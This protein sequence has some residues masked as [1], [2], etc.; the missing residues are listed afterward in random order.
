MRI[1]ARRVAALLMAMTLIGVSGNPAFTP[2][3]YAAEGDI[4][5]SSEET[6]SE[7]LEQP[8]AEPV[9]EAPAQTEPPVTEPPATEAPVQ[10]EPPAQTEPPVTEPPAT[11]ASVQTEPPATEP[12]VTEAPATE[13]PATEAPATEAPAQSESAAPAIEAS[14]QGTSEASTEAGQTEAKATEKE[15]EEEG[16]SRTFETQ[17]LK[18]KITLKLPKGQGVAESSTLV[19]EGV[20][21]KDDSKTRSKVDKVIL[22]KQR[23]ITGGRVYSISLKNKDEVIEIPEGTQ[24]TFEQSGGI[25]LNIQPRLQ[26]KTHIYN[27]SKD[28]AQEISASISLNQKQE[29]TGFSFST[30]KKLSAF[31]LIAEE[32]RANDGAAVSRGS[33]ISSIGDAGNFA[34]VA[35]A[36]NGIVENDSISN[37]GDILDSLAG[38]SVTLANAQ[39]GSDAAVVN[40]FTDSDGH[41]LTDSN[42]DQDPMRSVL[43]ENNQ[44]DVSGRMV[45]VNYVVTNPGA[46]HVSLPHYDVVSN[47]QAIDKDENQELGGRLVVTVT[48]IAK[49]TDSNYQLQPYT[50]EVG[51]SKRSVGT[52]LVPN[53][54]VSTSGRLV[55]A[56]YA[57]SVNVA[58]GKRILKA[59][60]KAEYASESEAESETETETETE[61]DETESELPDETESELPDETESEL[62]DETVQ[63][64]ADDDVVPDG[65]IKIA[66]AP[67]DKGGLQA[68]SVGVLKVNNIYDPDTS[69]DPPHVPSPVPGA[70]LALYN[71][72][73]ITY[74]YTDVV[75]GQVITE[76]IPANTELYSWSSNN[77]PVD[78]SAYLKKRNGSALITSMEYEIREKNVPAGYVKAWDYP[79]KCE[80]TGNV[81]NPNVVIQELKTLVNKSFLTTYAPPTTN[82]RL[83][84]NIY[85]GNND[86][87]TPYIY[88]VAVRDSAETDPAKGFLENVPIQIVKKGTTPDLDEVVAEF[89]SAD[90]DTPIDLSTLG[91]VITIPTGESS[92]VQEFVIREADVYP[93]YLYDPP[94]EIEFTVTKS[95]VDPQLSIT[96][97][98]DVKI[99]H[100]TQK[101]FSFTVD[102]RFKDSAGEAVAGIGFTLKAGDKT[103]TTNDYTI[104]GNTPNDAT[105]NQKDA[106]ITLTESGWEKL[107]PDADTWEKL[108]LTW[109]AAPSGYSYHTGHISEVTVFDNTQASPFVTQNVTAIVD[110]WSFNVGA[111]VDGTSTYLADTTFILKAGSGITLSPGT[112]YDNDTT[113]SGSRRTITLT[114]AGADKVLQAESLTLQSDDPTSGYNIKGGSYTTP[115]KGGQGYDIPLEKI[116]EGTLQVIKQLYVAES[117][118]GGKFYVPEPGGREYYVAIFEDAE[119]T[120]MVGSPQAMH[121]PYSSYTSQFSTSLSPAAKFENLNQ[122]QYYYLAETDKNGTPVTLSADDVSEY[123]FSPNGNVN[124]SGT[125]VM[126]PAASTDTVGEVVLSN[127]YAKRVGMLDATF[128]IKVNVVDENNKPLASTLTA[129]FMIWGGNQTHLGNTQAV[130]LANESAKTRN[131]IQYR[132]DAKYGNQLK[133]AAEMETLKDG[134]GKNVFSEYSLVDPKNKYK[135]LA[136]G[137]AIRTYTKNNIS[138]VITNGEKNVQTLEFTLKKVKTEKEVAEL[139]L[140]KAVTYKKTPIRVNKTYYIGI[141]EDAA[142]KKI[143]YKRAMSLSNASSMTSTL[144]INLYKRPSP[145]TITLYFAETDKNGKVMT[146]GAKSGYDISLNKTSVTLSP[147][148]TEEDIVLTNN[149]RAGSVAAANLTNPNSGFAG[150]ASALAK[151]Q[152]LTNNELTASMPTGDDTPYEPFALAT[153]ISAAIILLL[154][155]LLMIRRKLKTRP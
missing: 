32:N 97:L 16:K 102:A 134:S 151:A 33:V 74:T 112:D 131:D 122:G 79:F 58:G 120:R 14:T 1:R 35:E 34:A 40:V 141:F 99:I 105:L 44:I 121:V 89:P 26:R 124:L 136:T 90:A 138:A 54:T 103:L 36:V 42:D 71:K 63:A 61:G 55:G 51:V 19:C 123:K 31:A 69:H 21:Y 110:P 114:R 4:S 67:Y 20:K 17:V 85:D 133:V 96:G 81:D 75:T 93:G 143:L 118:G 49:G 28:S 38:Y 119:L 92:I 27:V 5:A 87:R 135:V 94:S 125:R 15:T 146:S 115:V 64:A 117:A 149:I 152:A 10:T 111:V 72:R 80:I 43:N 73:D 23:V 11:E 76:T 25:D 7:T 88:N 6:P 24:I 144:K 53:G 56:V 109:A 104:K 82:P 147:T 18:G 106:K 65:D 66:A 77:A 127:F 68:N 13:A 100:F 98:P 108:T 29:V 46:G 12:A 47:G 62:P 153:G 145:H 39:S 137:S 154:L 139:K 107:H 30:P 50:G 48:S 101:E 95:T 9:T 148:H 113:I 45:V 130:K 70:T 37:S 59:T 78:I 126:I 2:A 116:P 91:N 52:Y 128:Q 140:T 132:W 57:R 60:V 84:I 83:L 3:V 155:A 142:H 8:P 22:G 150:D 129:D 86:P 41:V